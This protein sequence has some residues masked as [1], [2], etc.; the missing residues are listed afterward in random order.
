VGIG[1]DCGE[2]GAETREQVGV[3][4]VAALVVQT[5]AEPVEDRRVVGRQEFADLLPER[6]DIEIVDRDAHDG[7]GIGKQVRLHEI[8]E[9]GNEFSLGQVT[10]S[11]EENEDAGSR[12]S[13]GKVDGGNL[14]SGWEYGGHAGCSMI[15]QR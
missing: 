13:T 11:A 5:S 9:G 10:G 2:T 6:F 15:P 7:E 1:I 8:K 3:G 14:G 12:N 4:E